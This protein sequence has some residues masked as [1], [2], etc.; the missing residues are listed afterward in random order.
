ME[1]KN[2]NTKVGVIMMGALA[3]ALFSGCE[4]G[5]ERGHDYAER[6]EQKEERGEKKNKMKEGVSSEDLDAQVSAAVERY[7]ADNKVAFGKQVI[8]SANAFQ[9]QEAAAGEAEKAEKVKDVPGIREGDHVLGNKDADLVLFEYSDY[10]C[11]FCKRFHPT[12][13]QLAKDDGIA[14][15]FRPMP[16]VHANTATPLHEAAEC[17]ADIEGNDAFW[18]FSAVLFEKAEAVNMENYGEELKALNIAKID[19]IKSCVDAGTYKEKVQKSIEEGYALG[20]NGTP[21]SILKNIKTGEVR[22][23]GG[24]YPY[25]A[26]KGYAEELTK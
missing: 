17:V 19:E 21:T 4:K 16:L 26:I 18:N 15:V 3:L 6:T 24:A 10:H 14:I 1:L 5:E 2:I 20:I 7:I 13:E 25:D 22:L 11:P 23:I 8:E 9:E 12:T